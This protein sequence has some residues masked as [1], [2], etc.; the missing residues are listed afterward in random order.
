MQQILGNLPVQRRVAQV[1]QHQVDVGAAGDD[2]GTSSPRG[3]DEVLRH[4]A[5]SGQSAPDA[6]AEGLG[7]GQLEGHRLACDHVRERAALLTWVDGGV[8]PLGEIA[9]ADD[10]P[11]SR[12]SERLVRGHRAHVRDRDGVRMQSG[13]DEAGEMCHVDH[14]RG[15]HL[16]GDLPESVEKDQPAK[17]TFGRCS[18]AS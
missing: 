15:S 11:A 2:M 7:P 3:L 5:G 8:D 4:E 1:D 18:R 12:A 13:G 6:L 16:V 9:A 14:E 10:R 17:I